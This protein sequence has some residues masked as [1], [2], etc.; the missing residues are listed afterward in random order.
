MRSGLSRAHMSGDP[1]AEVGRALR[2]APR[3][4]VR[5]ALAGGQGTA[6]PTKLM[7]K[8]METCPGLASNL[9]AYELR[10]VFPPRWAGALQLPVSARRLNRPLAMPG[11]ALK[12]DESRAPSPTRLMGSPDAILRAYWDP[13]PRRDELRESGSEESVRG[14]VERLD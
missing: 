7:A 5:K 12:R 9:G 14:L 11:I 8:F 1:V 6:R 2:C 4:G 3:K 10:S 13:E